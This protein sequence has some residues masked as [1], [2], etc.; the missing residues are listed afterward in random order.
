MKNNRV[1]RLSFTALLMAMNIALSSF[2][3]PVPGGH[4]YLN[5]VIICL[6]A[7][8]LNPFE[9]FMVGGVGSFLGDFFFYPD[10]MFVSLFTHGLQALLI[11]YLFKNLKF[12]NKKVSAIIALCVGIVIMVSGYTFGRAFIYS[13]K[14]YAIL[15][16]P[17]QF[18][19]AIV[20]ALIGYTLFF[21]F[22]IFNKVDDELNKM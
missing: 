1:F 18:L 8:L 4:L 10:P 3:V 13:T 11:S 12:K 19:Q 21:K 16:L 17:F 22:K 7:L 9:A 5:D 15:K 14:E 20:G 6:S 2:G